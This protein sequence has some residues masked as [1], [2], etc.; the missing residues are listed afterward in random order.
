MAGIQFAGGSKRA[1]NHEIPLV[2]YIDFLLCLIAFLLVTAVWSQHS[3][4]ET[5]AQVPSGQPGPET[6]PLVFH[7][8]A[9]S[10]SSL[11]LRWQ[12]GATVVSQEQLPRQTLD[13]D[14]QVSFPGLSSQLSQQWR[15]LG[16]HRAT[17]PARDLAVLHTPG[18]MQFGEMAALLDAIR[19]ATREDASPAFRVSLATD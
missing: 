14:G 13:V 9:R 2:P 3:R 8:D 15:R 6:R 12:Q 19:G 1:L 18:D 7:L 4:L 16:R 11:T 17:D 5:D 10:R